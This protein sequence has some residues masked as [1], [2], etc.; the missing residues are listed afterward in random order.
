ME[1]ISRDDM[2]DMSRVDY[3]KAT[4]LKET[5]K[6]AELDYYLKTYKIGYIEDDR[7]SGYFW[8]TQRK[9]C[10][11][12]TPLLK[13]A[14]N[15]FFPEHP[16]NKCQTQLNMMSLRFSTIILFCP[17][18]GETRLFFRS[19]TDDEAKQLAFK[20]NNFT[21]GFT[22]NRSVVHQAPFSPLLEPS[23]VPIDLVDMYEEHKDETFLGLFDSEDEI[24]YYWKPKAGDSPTK[25]D[26]SESEPIPQYHSTEREDND[27]FE[28]HQIPDPPM[29][30]TEED[31]ELRQFTET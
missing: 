28:S 19:K 25:E 5:Q 16:Y 21:L 1:Q 13:M 3:Q 8:Y 9:S 30:E 26:E 12:D 18:T 31:H 27:E 11:G 29:D 10:F 7:H 6:Q 2:I 20:F 15:Y 23:L 24:F 17:L 22:K 14:K 4:Q